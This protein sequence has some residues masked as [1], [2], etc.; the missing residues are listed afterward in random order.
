V[1]RCHRF[2]EQNKRLGADALLGALKHFLG[3]ASP[4]DDEP[5]EETG[6]EIH[7]A[8]GAVFIRA[9]LYGTVSSSIFTSGSKGEFYFYADGPELEQN[10]DSAFRLIPMMPT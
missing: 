4:P 1:E 6:L 10:P 2:F 8:L 3:D 9:P 5:Q 7:G